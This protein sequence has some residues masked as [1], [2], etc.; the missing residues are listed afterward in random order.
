MD[1]QIF[2]IFHSQCLKDPQLP[3]LVEA[4]AVAGVPD[5]EDTVAS[6]IM[7]SPVLGPQEKVTFL[8]KTSSNLNLKY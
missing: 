3:A 6:V 4:G 2:S 7:K 1:T 5:S 8:A